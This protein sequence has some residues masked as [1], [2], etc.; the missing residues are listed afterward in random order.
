MRCTQSDYADTEKRRAILLELQGGMGEDV[1]IDTPFHY[2]YGKNIF[3]GNHVIINM[4]S[5]IAAETFGS[6]T[7]GKDSIGSLSGSYF[8]IS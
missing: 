5:G 1:A 6:E 4:N 8:V 2:D 7:L 3:V